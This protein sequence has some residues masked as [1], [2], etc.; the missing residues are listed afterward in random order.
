MPFM[1][2]ITGF[3]V[4]YCQMFRT[5]TVYVKPQMQ[6]DLYLVEGALLDVVRI[7]F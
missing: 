7:L 6:Y 2:M 3:F 1:C 4:F 5:L